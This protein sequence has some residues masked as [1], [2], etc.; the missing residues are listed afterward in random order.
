MNDLNKRQSLTKNKTVLSRLNPDVIEKRNWASFEKGGMSK[1][2]SRTILEKNDD[3]MKP[4]PYK[5]IVDTENPP[6][7]STDEPQCQGRDELPIVL[8]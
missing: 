5:N 8:V 1:N 3:Q 6:V 2:Y 4:L 7:I